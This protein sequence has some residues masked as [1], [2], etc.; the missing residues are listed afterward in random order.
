VMTVL[1]GLQG[2]STNRPWITL[3][4]ESS[5]HAQGAKFQVAH[6]DADESGQPQIAL[7][8]FAMTASRTITQVLFFKFSQDSAELR[9][10]ES[11]L[12]IDI[13]RLESAKEALA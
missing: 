10:A 11:K 13:A 2:M 12:V 9:K 4:D 7:M 3:F 1:K 6:V 5:R 8:C